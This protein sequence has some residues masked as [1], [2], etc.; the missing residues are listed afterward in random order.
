LQVQRSV[1]FPY[2]GIAPRTIMDE[3]HHLPT[4]RRLYHFRTTRRLKMPKSSMLVLHN[5]D[6]QYPLNKP[7]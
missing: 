4:T 3:L 2:Q 6:M 1:E 5:V 7:M